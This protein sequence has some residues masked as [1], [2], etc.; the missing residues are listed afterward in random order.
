V[1]LDGRLPP[2]Q[3]VDQQEY[4]NAT[5]ERNQKQRTSQV[6][7]QGKIYNQIEQSNTP[8]RR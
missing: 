3:Q 7:R 1:W 6:K 5:D 2:G 8:V 4:A